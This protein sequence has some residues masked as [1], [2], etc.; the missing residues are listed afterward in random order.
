MR[1]Q[2]TMS[3]ARALA[4]RAGAVGR[5][6]AGSAE[7]PL[8]ASV[9]LGVLAVTEV[10]ILFDKPQADLI[11]SLFVGVAMTL[12]LALAPGHL[13]VAAGMITV[14]TFAG[15]AI[16]RRL[17][18]AALVA[19]G[20]AFYLVGRQRSPRMSLPMVIPFLALAIVGPLVTSSGP[21]TADDGPAPVDG[22]PVAP[23]GDLGTTDESDVEESSG[24]FG[25]YPAFMAA[26]TA[27]AAGTGWLRRSRDEAKRRALSDESVADSVLEHAARGERARIARELHDVVAHHISKVAVQA[28]TARLTTA[29][30]PAEGAERL[31]VIGDT[32][33]AAL[34]E[35]R[36]LLGVLREDAD[37]GAPAR[38]PPPGLKELNE[39]IDEARES[40]ARIRLIVRGSVG[41]LDPGVELTAYRIVQEALTNARRHAAGAAVDV[42]MCYDAEALRVLVR[43]NGPGPAGR[44]TGSSLAGHGLLGMRERAATVG[45]DVTASP[46]PVSGFVVDARLPTVP[47]STA[48]NTQ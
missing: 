28:E 5:R 32:A 18:V 47:S 8:V 17:P 13:L 38:R 2:W 43:D 16:D 33:R 1:R 6:I 35:M 14:A 48:E 10:A 12:P 41:P 31:L 29:G 25:P 23:T 21:D 37:S 7:L 39:L 42:E 36:R 26:L 9:L 20:A 27:G 40:G 3:G 15:F 4:D 22:R 30:L 45:G 44:E 19:L 46:G 34:T 24:D 11:P